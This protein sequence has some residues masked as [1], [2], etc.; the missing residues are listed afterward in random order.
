MHKRI[1]LDIDSCVGCGACVVACMDQNDI[2]P[3]EG[4]PA[5]RRIYRIEEGEFPAVTIRHVS[6]ACRHCQ[7]SPCMVKCL[8]GAITKDIKSGAL[9]VDRELC[10]GCQTCFT[11]CPLHI[12]AYDRDGKMQLCNLCMGRVEAGLEPACVRICP[13]GALR[14]DFVN[15]VQEEKEFKIACALVPA[16][17]SSQSVE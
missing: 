2:Y 6:L 12:P 17:H 10:I 4:Q 16:I 1:Y 7:E 15:K 13:V 11:A 3:E 8:S 14:F 5:W 9:A